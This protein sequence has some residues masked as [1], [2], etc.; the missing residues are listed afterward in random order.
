MKK[1]AEKVQTDTI[2]N[3]VAN[4]F[5]V[6]APEI[7][8]TGYRVD[9][10]PETDVPGV[11]RR[12]I[13]QNKPRLGGYVYDGGCE[14]FL[15][16]PLG[17]MNVA[18][19]GTTREGQEF[20]IL[21]KETGRVR[22]T[23]ARFLQVLNL[24][25]RNGMR[26][27]NLQL[28]GRNFFD[29]NPKVVIDIPE[30]RLQI[31]P[32][33]DTSIRQ[34][35]NGLLL[36]CDTRHKVMRQENVLA[37]IRECLRTNGGQYR[38]AAAKRIIGATV[39][40]DYNNAT[41]RIS[42]IDWDQHPTDTFETRTGPVTFAAYYETKYNLQIQDPGQPL[43]VSMASAR[44]IRAGQPEYI[45]LVPELC[46]MTGLTD[47]DRKNFQLMRAMAER[48]RMTPTERVNRLELFSRR[49][50]D[51][52]ACRQAF[53]EN[54]MQ[55]ERNLVQF[56]ARR[57]EP[58]TLYKG[59]DRKNSRHAIKLNERADWTRDLQKDMFRTVLDTELKNWFYVY[60]QKFKG[61]ADDF[62]RSFM[63][64]ANG[65]LNGRRLVAPRAVQIID[66]RTSTYQREVNQIM[67]EDPSFLMVVIP[68][69]RDEVYSALKKMTIGESQR[70]PV[71]IQV[72]TE[73]TCKNNRNLLSIATKV[74]VSSYQFFLNKRKLIF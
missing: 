25:L 43:L 54:R 36:N 20:T 32:G 28:V 70:R 11:R 51:T 37:I 6:N 67:C 5:K 10:K 60:P 48:T 4:Y 39:L 58:E 47:N 62:M 66:D 31:W 45:L 73:R 3:V 23:E 65:F 35:E 12:L 21:L 34:H 64:A 71:A 30:F 33:Y 41:Y 26:G 1:Q 49:M 7:L 42:D 14:L 15:L 44:N 9:F 19:P 59:P 68:N 52:P 46:R 56:K 40:T 8:V 72:V 38:E 22:Y 13:S 61:I 29:A 74:A 50:N 2:I 16:R 53:D 63:Q 27:L 69:K 18:L 55:I 57:F 17:E 24:I